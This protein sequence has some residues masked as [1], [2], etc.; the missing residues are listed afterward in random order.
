MFL[1]ISTVPGVVVARP[2]QAQHLVVENPVEQPLQEGVVRRRS[3][4]QSFWT[5]AEE[6]WK[7]GR[8]GNDVGG[9]NGKRNKKTSPKNKK[10]RADRHSWT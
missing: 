1:H 5:H 4:R 6:A 10:R 9:G 8:K 2:A 7:R 3:K